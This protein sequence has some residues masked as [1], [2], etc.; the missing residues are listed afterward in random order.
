MPSTEAL[1]SMAVAFMLAIPAS[2]QQAAGTEAAADKLF[3]EGR[4]LLQEKKP[5]EACDA[6]DRSYHLDAAL[7]TLLNRADCYE[8]IGRTA[9]AWSDFRDAATWAERVHEPKREQVARQRALALESKLSRLRLTAPLGVQ[10]TRDG[11]DVAV[12]PEGTEVPVDPG[13]HEIRATESGKKGWTEVVDVPAGPASR[14]VSVPA[15]EL[16]ATPG[17]VAPA[18]DAPTAATPSPVIV[19]ASVSSSSGAPASAVGDI[20]PASAEVSRGASVGRG[21]R[22]PGG[23]IAGAGVAV[24]GLGI[25]GIAYSWSV[26]D[27]V[28]RQ[29]PGGPNYANPTVTR[30]Q[31]RALG[32]IYPGALVLTGLGL[33]ASGCGVYLFV[34]PPTSGGMTVGMGG[35]L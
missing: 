33:V 34:S 22:V 29:Q 5:Q 27:A 14:T 20:Q 12:P 21:S 17:F 23:I 15:L 32:W 6:F 4:R 13:R 18:T 24:A 30:A 1:I 26:N 10:V 2:A 7:G 16:I 35:H 19:S 25:A 8:Q 28:L 9:S 11:I 3:N 31:Y